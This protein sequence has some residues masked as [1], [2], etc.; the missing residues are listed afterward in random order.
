MPTSSRVK[1]GVRLG[2]TIGLILGGTLLYER[3]S[4]PPLL[5]PAQHDESEVLQEL[6]RA[7]STSLST[8]PASAAAT[9][10]G[11]TV[12]VDPRTGRLRPPTTQQ[13]RALATAFRQQF[14][15]PSPYTASSYSNGTLSIVVGQ[16]LL[17]FSVA[18]VTPKGDVE[19][20]CLSGVE[21]TAALLEEGL[22]SPLTIASSKEE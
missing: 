22:P 9:V 10:A 17:N 11:I 13:K 19:V 12:Q 3:L 8:T 18:R 6:D 5:A 2:V 16:S 20:S 7:S 1:H 21:D 14:S 4:L 15:Q